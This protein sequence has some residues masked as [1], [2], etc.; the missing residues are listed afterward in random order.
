M[1][2]A[3]E[4]L[5][6]RSRIV[7]RI[8]PLHMLLLVERARQANRACGITGQLIYTD[9]SFVQYVEGPPAAIDALWRKFGRDPRH[10]DIELLA[11]F[12]LAR[13]RHPDAPLAFS[14]NAYFRQY[15][16]TD[17]TT[18]TEG[19][20]EALIQSCLALQQGSATSLAVAAG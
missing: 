13:R 6:Y 20:V 15:Q 10:Y 9:H 3:L 5:L 12:A 17:F 2:P 8:G 19:D 18:A 4:A 7:N 1:T 16:M 11:R 14:S